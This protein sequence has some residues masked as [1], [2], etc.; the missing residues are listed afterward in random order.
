WN[1]GSIVSNVCVATRR[2]VPP[3]CLRGPGPPATHTRRSRATRDVGAP[4]TATVVETR[5]RPGSM[6]L[7]VPDAWFAAQ[8][9]PAVTASE[10]GLLPTGTVATTAAVSASIRDTVP[11]R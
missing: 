9:A 11:S 8:T 4:P 6:R 7:T 2:N 10:D 5:F 3:R 1:A